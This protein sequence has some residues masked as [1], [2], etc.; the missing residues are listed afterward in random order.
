MKLLA[1]AHPKINYA[2]GGAIMAAL[3]AVLLL[4]PRGQWPLQCQ[5]KLATGHACPSC[6]ITRGVY[7]FFKGHWHEAQQLNAYALPFGLW[8]VA[9]LLWRASLA[10]YYGLWHKA[11]SVKLLWADALLTLGGIMAS[12]GPLVVE[13]WLF[14]WQT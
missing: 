12:V 2:L 13:T 14:R 3:L 8:W 7:A 1:P 6:G 9:Q 4:L 5:V 11:G 10:V